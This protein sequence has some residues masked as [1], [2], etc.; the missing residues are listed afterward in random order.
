L[1]E[2]YR[3]DAPEVMR[4]STTL[5]TLQ[6]MLRGRVDAQL[7]V[8]DTRA[9]AIESRLASIDHDLA[10][11][12]RFL[13]DLPDKE[14]RLS[15]YDLRYSMIKDRYDDLLNKA[16]TAA[17]NEI[18]STP[19]TVIMLPPPGPAVPRRP[20]DYVRLA[21]APTF[22]LVVGVGLAFF[23]DGL[24]LTVRTAGHAE[25]PLALPVLAAITERRR[26]A[27]A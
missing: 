17:V 21:L 1:R 6:S 16:R 2:N 5:D 18:A 15:Q 25:E 13:T 10:D 3:D 12:R 7:Q 14:S 9:S 27:R 22:S 24:D 11:A 26:R 8:A 23:L 4:A 19:L 20:R